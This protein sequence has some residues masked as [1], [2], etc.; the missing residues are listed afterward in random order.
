MPK[1][2]APG[3]FQTT[4]KRDKDTE[5]LTVWVLIENTLFMHCVNIRLGK[6]LARH[7]INNVS[8]FICSEEQYDTFQLAIL[9][10][11]NELKL[12][13]LDSWSRVCFISNVTLSTRISISK[14]DAFLYNDA[15]F[16]E[17]ETTPDRVVLKFQDSKYP[18]VISTCLEKLKTKLPPRMVTQVLSLFLAN[19]TDDSSRPFARFARFLN[20]INSMIEYCSKRHPTLKTYLSVAITSAMGVS[21]MLWVKIIGPHFSCLYSL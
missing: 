1:N 2:T 5:I 16:C 18:S 17:M 7:A 13:F 3:K 8:D 21:L 10:S 19:S 15:L 20:D 12:M 9:T 6:E 14:M 4:S 11:T